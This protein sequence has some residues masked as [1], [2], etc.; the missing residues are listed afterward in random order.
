MSLVDLQLFCGISRNAVEVERRRAVPLHALRTNTDPGFGLKV[1][2]FW[3]PSPPK[4][5]LFP[6]A[7]LPFSLLSF[8]VVL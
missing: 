3:V 8:S 1:S 6:T 4:R 2:G 7:S 5:R